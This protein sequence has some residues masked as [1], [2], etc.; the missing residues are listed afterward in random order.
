MILIDKVFSESNDNIQSW[1][2]LLVL[3]L[4]VLTGVINGIHYSD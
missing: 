3:E 2:F 1:V 4:T